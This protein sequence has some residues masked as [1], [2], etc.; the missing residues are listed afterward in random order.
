MRPMNWVIIVADSS[1]SFVP[2]QA[3]D[4]IA[5]DLLWKQLATHFQEKLLIHI[6]A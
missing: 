6:R 5:L 3:I 2:N 4:W 1:L